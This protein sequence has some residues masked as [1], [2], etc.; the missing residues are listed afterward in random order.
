MQRHHQQG[1][2][3]GHRFYG[4]QY[5][6]GDDERFG[7]QEGRSRGGYESSHEQD[8]DDRGRFAGVREQDRGGYR[9]NDNAQ[10]GGGYQAGSASGEGG[11]YGGRD[12]YGGG[13]GDNRPY[14]PAYEHGDRYRSPGNYDEQRHEWRGYGRGDHERQDPT[15]GQSLQ[16]GYDR[17]HDWASSSQRDDSE[18]RSGYEGRPTGGYGYD[19][20]RRDQGGWN[21]GREDRSG[22]TGRGYGGYGN[23][24]GG[25][26]YRSYGGPS[27]AGYDRDRGGGYGNNRRDGRGDNRGYG[28]D[29]RGRRR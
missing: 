7:G 19:Q 26:G 27:D 20:G 13:N 15:Y 3:P 5:R 9:S 1:G 14:A 11:S 4:N 6:D 8:R 10:F 28:R 2:Q 25:G 21:D 18:R 29:D 12:W 17:S 23:G 16:R 24:E 22:Y